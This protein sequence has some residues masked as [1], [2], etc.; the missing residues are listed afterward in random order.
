MSPAYATARYCR[1]NY[2]GQII[3][4]HM[5]PED[6]PVEKIVEKAKAHADKL[7]EVAVK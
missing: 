7:A 6:C 1:L 5:M 2:L 4:N 3:S